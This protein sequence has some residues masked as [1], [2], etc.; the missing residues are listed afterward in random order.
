[1]SVES[2]DELKWKRQAVCVY[3]AGWLTGWTKLV[4]E[5][6]EGLGRCNEFCVEI[7]V[8]ELGWLWPTVE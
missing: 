3:L 1:M 2:C 8:G 4:D 7:G 5:D 6:K